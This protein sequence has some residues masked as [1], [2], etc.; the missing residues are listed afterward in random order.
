MARI[1]EYDDKSKGT[2]DSSNAFPAVTYSGSVDIV[3]R[4]S[5]AEASMPDTRPPAKLHRLDVFST[6]AFGPPAFR[7]GDPLPFLQFVEADAIE[8]R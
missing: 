7:V 5:R 6:R 1:P 8:A 3:V 2:V 4:D